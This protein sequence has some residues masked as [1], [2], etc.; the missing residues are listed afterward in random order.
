MRNKGEINLESARVTWD[1]RLLEVLY[2]WDKKKTIRKFAH[3]ENLLS[4]ISKLVW[5]EIV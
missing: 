5:C 2:L 4:R 3:G 1:A